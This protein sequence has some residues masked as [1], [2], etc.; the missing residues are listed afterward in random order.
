APDAD[1]GR[2]LRVVV[3]EDVE[4]SPVVALRLAQ[5]LAPLGTLRGAGERVRGAADREWFRRAPDLAPNK[6]RLLEVICDDL[7]VLVGPGRERADPI[8]AAGMERRSSSLRPP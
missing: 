8:R 1:R 7:H 5:A 4:R 2:A 6:T 3:C